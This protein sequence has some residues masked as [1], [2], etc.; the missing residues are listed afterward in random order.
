MFGQSGGVGGT[1]EH[2]EGVEEATFEERSDRR[3]PNRA[4]PVAER[5]KPSPR[6]PRARD[7]KHGPWPHDGHSKVRSESDMPEL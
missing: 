2:V 1:A 5:A 6:G 3:Q 7:P 4:A